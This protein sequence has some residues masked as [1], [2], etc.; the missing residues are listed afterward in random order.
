MTQFVKVPN[1][2]ELR[3]YTNGV[4][5][6]IAYSVDDARAQV[7]EHVGDSVIDL[8]ALGWRELG[9]GEPYAQYLDYE[10]VGDDIF[11]PGV[12]EE[13]PAGAAILARAPAHSWI[14]HR[15]RCYLGST[16]F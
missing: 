16:E 5:F 14:K 1:P 8:D 15:G 12:A 10:P 13:I 6:V 4:D 7:R 2:G 9:D 11:L 3:F